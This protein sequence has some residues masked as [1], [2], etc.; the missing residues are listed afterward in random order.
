MASFP[1]PGVKTIVT[2]P[3]SLYLT[4]KLHCSYIGRVFWSMQN[5]Y[6]PRYKGRTGFTKYISSVAFFL[7][8][9]NRTGATFS[10]L[11]VFRF[12][13]KQNIHVSVSAGMGFSKILKSKFWLRTVLANH[14]AEIGDL[15]QKLDL[16]IF[17]NSNP[18]SVF[19]F[20]LQ[21]V[22]QDSLFS[23]H[24]KF[25][26]PHN[27]TSYP[28]FSCTPTPH[29]HP[30]RAPTPTPSP[31]SDSTPTLLRELETWC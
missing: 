5:L 9:S 3:T 27:N 12:R 1:W 28:R 21:N 17:E 13:P 31:S 10:T 19:A 20:S 4:S 14:I 30:R 11:Q 8:W 15:S 16:S 25:I 18:R 23:I 7:E 24:W 29:S 6:L 26:P 2:Q 22:R